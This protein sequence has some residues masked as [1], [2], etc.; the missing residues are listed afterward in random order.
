MMK[1][2][3]SGENKQGELMDNI[4]RVN[5]PQMSGVTPHQPAKRPESHPVKKKSRL[6]K[7]LIIAAVVVAAVLVL[8]GLWFVQSRTSVASTIDG[9]KYQAVFFTNGQVYFGK[10]KA[11][12]DDY[13][14]MTDIYYLQAKSSEENKSNPQEASAQDASNVQL[15]KLGSEIHGPDDEMVVNKD[16][17]LFFENLKKDSNVSTTIASYQSQQKKQ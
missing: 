7:P 1:V 6:K 3:L 15:V 9:A 12:N 5:R 14:R 10:L 17:I 16:Q 8:A 11:L 13:M 2:S 4:N